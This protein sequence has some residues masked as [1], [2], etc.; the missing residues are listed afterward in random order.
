MTALTATQRGDL[1]EELLP[2]AALLACIVHGDGDHHDIT[3]HTAR[4]DRHELV[5]LLVVMAGLVDPEQRISDALTHLTYDETG[6]PAT[7]TPAGPLTIRQLA[8]DTDG[9]PGLG[10]DM[11]FD[12][13][14]MLTARRLYVHDG[15]SLSATARAVGARDSTVKTWRDAGGWKQPPV[16][17]EYDAG[18]KRRRR[19]A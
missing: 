3:H 10:A 6:R 4:Y 2:V 7:P 14:R 8:A 18:R 12:S 17:T 19:A 16:I 15:W 5:A 1:A 9:A 13:E 11:V